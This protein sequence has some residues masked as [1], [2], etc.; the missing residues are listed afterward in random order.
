MATFKGNMSLLALSSLI[1][2]GVATLSTSTANAALFTVGGGGLTDQYG[3]Y[4]CADVAGASL[5]TGTPVQAWDCHG[6]GNQQFNWNA[7]TIYGF[8]TNRCWQN[9]G[10]F[11]GSR[12]TSE[13]CQP[14]TNNRQWWRFINGEIRSW[15]GGN[16]GPLCLDA[17]SGGNGTQLTLRNCSGSTWQRWQIK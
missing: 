7:R 17:G 3:G 12:V 6:S 8:G 5:N 1:S 13:F 10:F 4:V 14:G 15:F 11:D 2:L 16:F 9:Q